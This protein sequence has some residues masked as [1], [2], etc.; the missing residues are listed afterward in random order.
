M[1]N[2][3]VSQGGVQLRAVNADKLPGAQR[4]GTPESLELG[5]RWGLVAREEVE[6]S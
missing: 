3:Y 5:V 2:E 6:Y 1:R 4:T